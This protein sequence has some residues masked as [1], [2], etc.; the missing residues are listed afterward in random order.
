MADQTVE[1][2]GYYLRWT[3]HLIGYALR[4]GRCSC[5]RPELVD[6]QP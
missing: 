6:E 2:V 1:G 5:L 3:W 4:G